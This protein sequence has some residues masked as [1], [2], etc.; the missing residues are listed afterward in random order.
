MLNFFFFIFKSCVD[1]LIDCADSECCAKDECKDSLMCLSSP[2]PLEIVLR[3]PTP[4]ISAS[5][6]QKTKFLIEEGSVQ[7]YAHRDD[8]ME[9]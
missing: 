1:G 6:Y 9:R 7:S 3:K 2:D 5:F 4:S 8:Y